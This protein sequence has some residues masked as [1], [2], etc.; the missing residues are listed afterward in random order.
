MSYHG[1]YQKDVAVFNYLQV[2]LV[3]MNVT[4][5]LGEAQRSL[6]LHS[7]HKL[8]AQQNEKAWENV[9]KFNKHRNKN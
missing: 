7:T 5:M 4:R 3:N 2:S 1:L 9:N 6:L 8:E